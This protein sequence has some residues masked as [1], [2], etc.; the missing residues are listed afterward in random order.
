V[1][2]RS[3]VVE[4]AVGLRILNQRAV[5]SKTSWPSSL[6]RSDSTVSCALWPPPPISP[7]PITPLSVSSS[8]MVRTKRPQWAP[9][10]WRSG[11]SSG[12]LTVVA[13]RSAILDPR[14]GFLVA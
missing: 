3:I 9:A 10:A 13:R 14:G 2:L 12:T 4:A 1:D 7:S 11:A 8:T 6:G 5:V